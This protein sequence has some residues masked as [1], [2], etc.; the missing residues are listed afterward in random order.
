MKGNQRRE[1]AR[2]HEREREEMDYEW[3]EGENMKNGVDGCSVTVGEKRQKSKEKKG[4]RD[5]GIEW[6][7]N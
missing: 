3:R 5:G 1:E 7:R 2:G 4:I 6:R